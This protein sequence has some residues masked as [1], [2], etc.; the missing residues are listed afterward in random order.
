[1]QN[2]PIRGLGGQASGCCFF[3][4]D[5]FGHRSVAHEG[6]A[7]TYN[8]VASSGGRLDSPPSAICW[9]ADHGI[10]NMGAGAAG[11]A[12]R[13]RVGGRAYCYASP[14]RRVA[15]QRRGAVTPLADRLGPLVAPPLKPKPDCPTT[16]R[17]GKH[18]LH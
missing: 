17:H 4:G 14:S 6:P 16:A 13:A 10:P 11:L 3:F 9:E 5:H 8:D 15:R 2:P 7:L 1:T 12:G 18:R